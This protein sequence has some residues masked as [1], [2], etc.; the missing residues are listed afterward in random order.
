MLD[1]NIALG[2]GNQSLERDNTEPMAQNPISGREPQKRRQT[3]DD[4]PASNTGPRNA[5]A[6]LEA[7]AR[8]PA[9][10]EGEGWK[11]RLFDLGEDTKAKM[12][13]LGGAG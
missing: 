7:E 12:S 3:A 6:L 10:D 1:R 9:R 8:E 13:E 2:H 5:T 4:Q 11:D